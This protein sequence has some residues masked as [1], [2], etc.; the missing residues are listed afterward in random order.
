MIK[1]P[2]DALP[3]ATPDEISAALRPFIARFVPKARRERVESLFLPLRPRT[4]IRA[5]VEA[6]D[7]AA[8]QFGGEP[9]FSAA[10]PGVYLTGSTRAYRTTFGGAQELLGEGI[11]HENL[12]V[13]SAGEFGWIYD[14]DQG[15]F[16]VS[17]PR[18]PD[19]SR[20]A[21]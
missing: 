2:F 7:P 9:T 11:D 6:I 17:S 19:R 18:A 1:R 8:L 21:T 10:W 14:D 4:T 3:T 12:F 5:M 16:L 13:A 20:A 15:S